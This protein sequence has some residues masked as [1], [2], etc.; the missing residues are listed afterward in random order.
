MKEGCS[1]EEH[2]Q[3]NDIDILRVTPSVVTEGAVVVT[4]E[5]AVVTEGATVVT[6]GAVVVTGGAVVIMPK[7]AF[8]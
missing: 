2:Q 1:Q 3:Q 7:L 8:T 5:A 4:E 6:G